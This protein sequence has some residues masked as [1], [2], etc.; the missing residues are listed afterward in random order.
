MGKRL[1]ALP[2][3]ISRTMIFQ[4]AL[5]QKHSRETNDDQFIT[6]DTLSVTKYCLAISD[7]SYLH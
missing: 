5:L 2:Q 6:I 4:G 7:L 3:E 1:M